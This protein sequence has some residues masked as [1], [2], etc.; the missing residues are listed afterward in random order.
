L[1]STP[2][3][4]RA[5]LKIAKIVRELTEPPTDREWRHLWARAKGMEGWLRPEE[6]R[7]LFDAAR[8]LP[9]ESTIVEIG[10]FKGRSTCCL[11]GGCREHARV[12]AVDSFDGGPNL[13]R[14]DSLADFNRNI[15]S[16]GLSDYVEP[17]VGLS[18]EVARKWAKPIH[19]LFIDGSH[20]YDDVLADFN[21]FFPHLT[22]RSFVAFHD[23][24]N[25]A[26]PGVLQ[27]WT[28]VKSLLTNVGSCQSLAYGSKL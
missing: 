13:P 4:V 5:K 27:V 17:I 6:G 20:N 18:S 21:G 19:L 10:S 7:W 14:A 2:L 9:P 25:R 12:Y 24:N 8:A 22:K 15:R 16:C 23:V 26:W 11:A 28:D 1:A 3:A